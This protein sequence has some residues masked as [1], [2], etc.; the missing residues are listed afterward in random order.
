MQKLFKCFQI[1]F[2]KDLMIITITLF[3]IDLYIDVLQSI[4]IYI[5]WLLIKYFQKT[6]KHNFGIHPHIENMVFFLLLVE[7]LFLKQKA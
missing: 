1:L 2:L 4:I 6:V 5:F 3:S 7:P